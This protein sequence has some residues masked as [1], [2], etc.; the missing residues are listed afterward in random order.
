MVTAIFVVYFKKT[1]VGG[2]DPTYSDFLW[3]LSISIS[4]GIVA[5]ISP[6]IGT[7]ADLYGARK[8]I[9]LV[10]TAL[11]IGGLVALSFA[12]PGMIVFGM[13]AFII[14]NA[15]FEGGGVLYGSLL[16]WVTTRE[17]IAKLSGYGWS[18]GYIGGL[19]CLL[20]VMGF[21]KEGAISIVLLV[22]AAW[23]LVFSLPLFLFVNEPPA[24]P[25][26]DK[27]P[28]QSLIQTLKKIWE[29]PTLRRFFIA[30]FIYNDAIITAFSFSTPFAI[31]ILRFTFT[32]L[33]GMVVA[34]QITGA[35]GAVAFGF[36]ADRI[37]N[38][39]TIVITLGIWVAVTLAAF[40]VA[41]DL[42]L[43]Q[44]DARLAYEALVSHAGADAATLA[45]ETT[46]SPLRQKVYWGLVVVIGFAMGAT[47]SSS[48]AFLAAVS[49]ED[50]SGR[51]F[52]FYAI[53]GRFSAVV[54]PALFGAL[55]FWTGS[56]A[57]GVFSLVVFFTVGLI[58]ML[59]VSEEKAR[60]EFSQWDLS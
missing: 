48:R 47:Q 16:P 56:K 33:M 42:P 9:L 22:V 6:L 31:D 10:Y 40:V 38:G 59:R 35:I 4:A 37:G 2:D 30:Y 8:R 58:L 55:A 45:L 25:N 19:V 17:N 46:P 13:I 44:E 14:A 43:W 34:V 60:D 18:A 50:A 23:F 7:I 54:G 21:A 11:S 28:F 5:L 27:R 52:G 49:P 57:W 29:T 3:G 39:R 41:L 53:A 26:A 12:G 32:E 36:V 20:L 1:I 15:G 24:N 51:L